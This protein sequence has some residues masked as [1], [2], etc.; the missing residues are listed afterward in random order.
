MFRNVLK[1]ALNVVVSGHYALPNNW[2]K[3]PGEMA[4]AQ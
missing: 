1:S 2:L 4:I 3:S